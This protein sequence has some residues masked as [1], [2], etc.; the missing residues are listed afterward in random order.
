MYKT[1]KPDEPKTFRL[2]GLL[3]DVNDNRMVLKIVFSEL[4]VGGIPALKP[5]STWVSRL[6]SGR[7]LA[8]RIYVAASR[9]YNRMIVSDDMQTS[10]GSRIWTQGLPRLGIRPQAYEL[11]FGLVPGIDPY[12]SPDDDVRWIFDATRKISHKTF[13]P[14]GL[15]TSKKDNNDDNDEDFWS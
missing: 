2:I 10:S 6:V 1:Q 4:K 3:G 9:R 14:G 15:S 11:G 13:G 12:N 8:A 7:N 5:V